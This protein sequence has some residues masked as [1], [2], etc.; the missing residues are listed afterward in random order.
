MQ[1]IEEL[2]ID[3]PRF[4]VAKIAQEPIDARESARQVRVGGRIGER[5]RLARVRVPE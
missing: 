1:L 3:R 4:A 2:R 5:K